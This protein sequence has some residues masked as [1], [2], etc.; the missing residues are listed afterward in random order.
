MS[1]KHLVGVS[2][3]VLS[4]CASLETTDL[5]D[6][7]PEEVT[8]VLDIELLEHNDTKPLDYPLGLESK[9]KGS[10]VVR[11]KEL[12]GS[13]YFEEVYMGV[14]G[15]NYRNLPTPTDKDTL[16]TLIDTETLFMI[17]DVYQAGVENSKLVDRLNSVQEMSVE[18]RNQ[19]LRLMRIEAYRAKRIEE[20]S[21]YYQEELQRQQKV[22]AVESFTWKVITALAL[23]VAI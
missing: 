12:N 13:V 1:L 2:I 7:E 20:F 4:G 8:S 17:R 18:E 10:R 23:A 5:P 21:K 6:Y 14:E 9:V 11:V 19:L 3:L 16:F 15:K 22:N